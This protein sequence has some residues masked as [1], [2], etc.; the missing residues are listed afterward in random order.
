MVNKITASEKPKVFEKTYLGRKFIFLGANFIL[1][2]II[3]FFLLSA[4]KNFDIDFIQKEI[5]GVQYLRVTRDAMQH[6]PQHQL[7]A[8]AYLEGKTDLKEPLLAVQAVIDRE[9]QNILSADEKL[10]TSIKTTVNPK[11]FSKNWQNLK[12]R[13]FASLSTDSDAAHRK[14]TDDLRTLISNI[15]DSSNLIFDPKLDSSYVVDAVLLKLPE[16]QDLL[17][18]IIQLAADEA[19]ESSLFD[20]KED[21]ELSM[22]LGVGRSDFLK[23]KKGLE[24]AFDADSTGLA[25]SQLQPF[26][27]KY[28]LANKSFLDAI[29]S[30]LIW[31]KNPEFTA[32]SVHLLGE[33]ALATNFELW[34]HAATTLDDFLKIRIGKAQHEKDY[35]FLIVAFMALL[36]SASALMIGQALLERKEAGRLLLKTVEENQRMVEAVNSA[37]DG[38]VITDP[39]QPD[40]PLIYVNQMFLE[41]TGYSAKDVMGRNCR[42]LQGPETDPAAVAQIRQAVQDRKP[43]KVTILNYR[44]DGTKFWNGLRISPVFSQGKLQ[45]FLGVQANVT[46]RKEAEMV[47]IA[48]RDYTASI[49]KGTPVIVCGVD[50]EGHTNFINPSGEKVTGYFAQELVGKNWW[51]IF[52][53]GTDYDQVK[54][55]F[56]DLKKGDVHDYEMVLISKNGERRTI[57][58]NTMKRLDATGKLIEIIGFGNDVTERR[59]AEQELQQN[60]E[61]FRF[62][63]LSAPVMVWIAGP[64]KKFIYVN[65][66]W[67]EFTGRKAEQELDDGWLEN[68]YPEDQPLLLS[69]YNASFNNRWDFKMEFRL[70]HIT[71][72]Y[73][74]VVTTGT[75]RFKDDG[76]FAGYIGSCLDIHERKKLEGQLLQSQKMETVGT[77]AGGIAHDLNNQLTPL[78]GYIDLLM[79][80]TS[81][82]DPNR[83][84]L[85]E[86]DQASRRCAEVVQRLMNFSR[87]STH[88]KSW[89][90]IQVLME[91][92]RTVLPKFLPKTIITEV[93]LSPDLWPVLGNDTELQTVFMN[94]AANAR[95]AML[96]G[97]RL[98]VFAENKELD[99]RSTHTGH[100]PGAYVLLSVKDSGKGIPPN[101]LQKIFEPFFTTKPKGQGTGLGLAMVFRIIKD[102]GGWIEVLSEVGKGTLF[103]VYL[104][105]DPT[106]KAAEGG[107]RTQETPPHGNETILFADDEEMLRNL[108]RILLERLGY[109]VLLARDGEE[110]VQLYQ[111][112]YSEIDAVVLDMTMPTLT[113]RQAMKKLLQIN[114]K[115]RILLASGY[116]SEGSVKDLIREGAM[117]FLPKPYTILPLAQALRKVIGSS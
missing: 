57:S 7:M 71:G 34:D 100:N 104:P 4:E 115:A 3:A 97:G 17:P 22:L 81:L 49:I 13:L 101:L 36:T 107:S 91:E 31:K 10:G 45:Y 51:N 65:R 76:S 28:S 33:K 114:P 18:Q 40:N 60:E 70:R 78:A 30:S 1:T 66:Y 20:T 54:K 5:L 63:L 2:I 106:Q 83:E 25:R 90:K 47:L 109:K 35:A 112:R 26:L 80:E 53:P 113:G 41:I 102:H 111:Q 46:R 96:E 110:A 21:P 15:G 56:Q 92:L 86:A 69:G 42:F 14:L 84:F 16:A 79:K 98:Q 74:W 61:A 103:Q 44:K 29:E 12:Q 73:R 38:I 62:T 23:L 64:D 67:L 95:D 59:R 52:Y 89:I 43:T 88:K 58:W 68:I 77:L 27:N 48:E 85:V 94:L 24:R 32:D 39:N 116:T 99:V 93:N 108:G 82:D 72:E 37:S 75:P 87:T 117:D 105:A 11:L 19:T 55:L 9:V 8:H 6:L 50:P